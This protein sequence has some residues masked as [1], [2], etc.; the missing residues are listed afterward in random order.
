MSPGHIRSWP[1][2]AKGSCLRPE[3]HCREEAPEAER[4]ETN[5]PSTVKTQLLQE[6]ELS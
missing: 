2:E 3:R 1:R 4:G 5:S 6:L